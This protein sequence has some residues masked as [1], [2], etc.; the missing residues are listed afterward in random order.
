M[1]FIVLSL[2]NLVIF[3]ILIVLLFRYMGWTVGK[4]IRYRK[5]VEK[6]MIQKFID[7]E[8]KRYYSKKLIR[9][10]LD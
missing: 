9:W 10:Q 2:F 1:V 6:N 7:K 3:F 5:T 4:V 8:N